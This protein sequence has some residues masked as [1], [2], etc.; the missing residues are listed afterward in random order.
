MHFYSYSNHCKEPFAREEDVIQ[1]LSNMCNELI[2]DIS[3]LEPG[4]RKAIN[5]FSRMMTVTH[6]IQNQRIMVGSYIKYVLQDGTQLERT[7][8]VRN[9]NAGLSLH[10]RKLVRI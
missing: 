4:L 1:E 5:N 3:S 10:N 2:E 8:L 9:L 6:S 7:R